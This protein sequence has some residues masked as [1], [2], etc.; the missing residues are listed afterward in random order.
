MKR[1]ETRT[2]TKGR[3]GAG[4]AKA[5][6]VPKT[7]SA[8]GAGDARA[9]AA[10]EPA[11]IAETLELLTE[12]IPDP[13][14]ELDHRDPW[15]L[16]IATILAAQSTDKTVNTV[17]PELFRRWPT[18]EALASAPRQEVEL[19]VYRTGFFRNKARA[20]QQCSLRLVEDHGGEVPRDIE[21]LCALP[22]VARKT[23]NV[24]LGIACGIAA[25]FA[26][27]THVA[28]VAKRLGWTGSADPVAIEKDL[29]AAIPRD[30]WIAASHRLVLHGRY[31]C[32][33]RAP[34]CEQCALAA[35]C[36]S[37]QV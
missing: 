12:S 11:P 35:V 14:C 2:E 19:V 8:P 5:A 7:A 36:P 15:T 30:Q 9:R 10:R 34:R 31:V 16:L 13:R 25:G 27:D 17:T 22:G 23:A 3:R 6:R 29:C 28:R 21:A 1:N 32:Q 33:A 4:P 20:I 18:P 24:V 26:V 37:R